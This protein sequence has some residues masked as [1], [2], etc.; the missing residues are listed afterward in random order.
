MIETP[1]CAIAAA[2]RSGSGSFGGCCANACE[3]INMLSTP[4]PRAMNGTTLV[5]AVSGIPNT[6]PTPTEAPT[7]SPIA[8]SPA[9]AR[10][11]PRAACIRH[12]SGRVAIAA[13]SADSAI[14]APLAPPPLAP[15]AAAAS[16]AAAVVDW[17]RIAATYSVIDPNPTMYS[18]AGA[19][20]ERATSASSASSVRWYDARQWRSG[21][22]RT[23]ARK[24]RRHAVRA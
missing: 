16:A 22:S 4:T 18:Q 10:Y 12:G 3:M 8:T 2:A 19:S 24:A 9:S 21:K 5:H 6:A 20:A 1:A 23:R 14:E 13:A 17:A 15:P 11:S 7:A